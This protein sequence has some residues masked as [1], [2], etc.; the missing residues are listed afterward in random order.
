MAVPTDSQEPVRQGHRFVL[1]EQPQDEWLAWRPSLGTG[2]VPDKLPLPAWAILE[3]TVPGYVYNSSQK[4]SGWVLSAN[5]QLIGPAGLLTEPESAQP[6]TSHLYLAGRRINVPEEV[7]SV[8]AGLARIEADLPG[9]RVFPV[10]LREAEPSEDLLI[11]VDADR[12]PVFI[13]AA[14]LAME[15]GYWLIDSEVPLDPSWHGA[16]AVSVADGAVV[17]LLLLD[18][19]RPRIGLYRRPEPSAENGTQETGNGESAGR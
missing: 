15:D 16:V 6:N 17:G 3:W 2:T 12:G 13:S 7:T 4:R 5:G 14:R 8:G 9:Q 11:V 18:E 19:E 10:E 1:H